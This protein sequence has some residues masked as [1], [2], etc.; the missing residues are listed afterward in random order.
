M[1]PPHDPASA[2]LGRRWSL[3]ILALLIVAVSAA[4]VRWLQRDA[5]IFPVGDSYA[6]L[7]HLLQF[8]DRTAT[9]GV[10]DFWQSLGQLSHGGRPPLYQIS[11]IPNLLILGRS[12]D[13]ATGV[14][15]FFSA[16]LMISAYHGAALISGRKAGLLAALL[17]AAYPPIVQLTRMYLPRSALPATCALSLWMLIWLLR[18]RSVAAALAFSASLAV[19]VL[20]HPAFIFCWA[21]PA[22]GF[23]FYI[24]LFQSE[25]RAPS[26]LRNSPR[27]MM[28]KLRSRLWWRGLLPGAL[29]TI[30]A[31]LGWYATH[32]LALLATQQRLVDEQ[33]DEFRGFETLAIDFPKV[34]SP[35]LWFVGTAPAVMSNVL[36][37]LAFAGLIYC[38]LRPRTA[39]SIPALCLL[40][41]AALYPVLFPVLDWLHFAPALPFVAVLTATWI[42]RLRR[43]LARRLLSALAALAAALCFVIATWGN[44]GGLTRAVA[45]ALGAPLESVACRRARPVALC[46]SAARP[47]ESLRARGDLRD[48]SATSREIL[49]LILEAPQCQAAGCE[50]MLVRKSGGLIAKQLLFELGS[51]WPREKLTI[52]DDGSHLWGQVYPLHYLL[53]ADFLIYSDRK[54][55]DL[56]QQ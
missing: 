50:V 29:M 32:G 16:I 40:A 28:Q 26:S 1:S 3:A 41:A 22:I 4:H 6:Y 53:G 21:A 46:P 5:T 8:L 38:L 20:V 48:R 13:S 43:V 45:G 42:F 9:Q 44:Q 18:S 23:G 30:V 17:V 35:I 52:H 54:G 33:L 27:W 36:A 37:V 2:A 56:Y 34:E 14:N 47:A 7:S 12:E 51:A 11:T 31:A 19:G 15:V 39:V 10:T 55:P 25:P 49:K 24:L